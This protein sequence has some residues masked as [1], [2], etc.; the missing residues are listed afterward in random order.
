LL[1]FVREARFDRLG[2]FVFSPEEGTA[3]CAMPDQVPPAVARR[4]RARLMAAQQEIALRGAMALKGA[5]DTVLLVR[6]ERG[7]WV[8]RSARQAPE[9]DGVTRVTGKATGLFARVR[10]TGTE[11]YDLKAATAPS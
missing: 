4:R 6:P 3:A 11:G 7:G 10:Y 5:A 9:V 8:A 2:V 1:E